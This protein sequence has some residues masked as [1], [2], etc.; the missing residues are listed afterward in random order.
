MSQ[1][2]LRKKI[3]LINPPIE[4]FYQTEKRQQP[5]GLRYIQAVLRKAGFETELID[6]LDSREKR[7]IP[8][9]AHLGYLK[10][11]YPPNDLS[12]FKLFTH[13]RHFGLSFDLLEKRIC[14]AQPD[15]IGIS[16]N[17]TP[18]FDMALKAAQV[19][20][21]I[22]P[23][24]PIIA[25]GHHATS[26]PASV[27]NS[28]FFD[29][30]VL[31][32]GE[33]S[34]LK[35]MYVLSEDNIDELNKIDGFAFRNENS[36]QISAP[37]IFIENLDTIPNPEM[38]DSIGMII[39]SRGCPKN[40]NFCS[41]SKVMGK[42][43]RFRSIDSVL[44]EME[45]GI[46][47]GV[48]N[49]DYED[50][51]LTI[52][53]KRAKQLFEGIINRFKDRSLKLSALNGILTDTLDEELVQLMS[54]AGFEWLNI[55]L[56]SG[57]QGMHEK[58]KR[59]QSRQKFDKVISWARKYKLKVV[60]YLIVGLPED[61]LDQMIEDIIYL[62][63][64]PVLIGPSI[65]YPP[66]GSVTFFNCIDKN[67]ISGKDFTLYRSSALPV[68]TENF[69]RR[70][71]ITLFRLVRTINYFKHILGTKLKDRET[72]NEYLTRNNF[73]A[74]ELIF[75]KKLETEEIGRILINQLF[76]FHKL[77]GLACTAGSGNEYKYDWIEYEI[78]QNLIDQWIEAFDIQKVL[79][80]I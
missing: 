19:C 56:V 26:E 72:I 39:T 40:C 45:F 2:N 1:P 64:Q 14:S 63:Y 46:K 28:G 21:S 10:K 7:T 61:T 15:F 12:P 43:V 75:A 55:P 59:F 16:V 38:D 4:D 27:L 32:E 74:D 76:K 8:L 35:L 70:D 11:Y 49:F 57:S 51:N 13:Y 36:I 73:P 6:C 3:L 62:A 34:F 44:H 66:P 79:P 71:L 78:S 18:Y 47:N 80:I 37:T 60:A 53:P 54:R 5:I 68:E 31:G 33:L 25:G 41:I 9:P 67:Y 50:D 52:N 30:V 17:F 77:R 58:I 42:K 24:I 69:S 22:F 23:G 65:F 48:F 20:K 29:Y